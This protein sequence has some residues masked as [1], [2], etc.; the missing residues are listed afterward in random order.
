MRIIFSVCLFFFAVL[1]F[2]AAPLEGGFALVNKV[3]V[4]QNER[5]LIYIHARKS[6]IDAAAKY[7]N[8]PYRYGGVTSRGLDCSGLIYRSF[9]DALDVELPRSAS[10]LYSWSEKI[11]FDKAQPGDFLFFKT[12]SNNDITHVALYLGG[13]K[14]IHS[15]SEGPRT[16]VIYSTLDE[17][18]WARTYAGAGRAFPEAPAGSYPDNNTSTAD[19]IKFQTKSAGGGQLLLGASFAPSW[20][21]ALTNGGFFR[22]FSSSF[23]LGTNVNV[24]NTQMFF[25]LE[26]RQ[27]YDRIL[28]VFRLPITLS[29]GISDKIRIFGGPVLSF[30]NASVKTADGVRDYSGGTSLFGAL[31]ITIAPYTFKTSRGDFAPY[32]EAAWQNYYNNNSPA[33][34][35]ADVSASLRLSTGL[36]YTRQIK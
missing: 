15:A 7:E 33:N 9:N 36:R 6:V 5:A 16:G 23:G 17:D 22:G 1:V 3:S 34:L 14:F 21:G 11:P 20:N 29:F 25:G 27:E 13:R 8:T 2:A 26:L 19:N 10:G 4:S 12:G 32:F 18:Y 35:N 31:G 30:G 28:G 24:L